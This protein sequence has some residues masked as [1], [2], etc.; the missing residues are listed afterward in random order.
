MAIVVGPSDW[1]LATPDAINSLVIACPESTILPDGSGI[2]YKQ[3]GTA[4][5]AAPASTEVGQTWNNST[6]T[7]VGNKPS[8]LDWPTLCTR[9][10][11]CGFNPADWCVLTCFE[12]FTYGYNC[13]AKWP[14]SFSSTCYWSS[15][16]ASS[17]N[18]LAVNITNGGT[19][20]P[21]KISTRLIRAFRRVT[22]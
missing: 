21:S 20:T 10:I 9:L 19:E 6:V 1:W 16:E 13:R 11:S 15:T 22:Y 12:L 18:A 5:I 4:Y 2:I 17:T 14:G 8:A 3:G 7:L